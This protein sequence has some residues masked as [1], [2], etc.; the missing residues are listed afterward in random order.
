MCVGFLLIQAWPKHLVSLSPFENLE[1][2]RGRTKHLYASTPAP[3]HSI[4]PVEHCNEMNFSVSS[5]PVSLALAPHSGKVSFAV[6]N[7]THLQ[8]LGLHSLKEVSDGNMV[9]KNNTQLCYASSNNWRSLFR[10]DEQ[11]IRLENNA[12]PSSCGTFSTRMAVFVFRKFTRFTTIN[13]KL[14]KFFTCQNLL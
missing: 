2:I 4:Q 6:L 1:I 9:V 7:V 14:I 8:Y 13:R 3:T 12:K 11:D 5:S 10:S